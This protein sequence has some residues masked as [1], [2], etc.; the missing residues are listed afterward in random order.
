VPWPV[1]R[2]QRLYVAVIPAAPVA[3]TLL[4]VLWACTQAGAA[5]P[6]PYVPLLNPLEV[7]QAFALLVGYAWWK[8]SGPH[9]TRDEGARAAGRALFAVLAFLALNAVVGRIVHFSMD[10]PFDLE[11]LGES[12]IFQ[13]GI[14]ILWGVV[15]GLLM[16]LSRLRL[17]RPVWMMGAALLAALILKLFLIDL[18]NVGGVARIVSFLATGV[19]ILLIGYFAPVPP[20]TPSPEQEPTT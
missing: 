17:D 8:N 10:V 9:L 4:W 6:L 3:A 1:E 20:R 16:T 15:A 13:T 2:F 18:G 11:R 5:Q 14:S 7:T 19:L 12:A